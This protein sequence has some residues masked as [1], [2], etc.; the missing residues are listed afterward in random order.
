MGRVEKCYSRLSY[1]VRGGA[2]AITVKVKGLLPLETSTPRKEQA[3]RDTESLLV[4]FHSFTLYYRC[5]R[6]YFLYIAAGNVRYM[7][8]VALT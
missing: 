4:C 8:V 3:L 7:V 2:V 6:G 5:Y 1:S